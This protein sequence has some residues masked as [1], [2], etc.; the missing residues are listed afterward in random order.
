MAIFQPLQI[1]DFIKRWH[2]TFIYCDILYNSFRLLCPYDKLS[3]QNT[4]KRQTDYHN[5]R[6]LPH[7][8]L[9]ISPASVLLNLYR[10]LISHCPL[11]W[12]WTFNPH[13]R[14]LWLETVSETFTKY[15]HTIGHWV[16]YPV[17]LKMQ[18]S[19]VTLHRMY[20]K[21]VIAW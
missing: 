13:V 20:L 15:L 5:M 2:H 12:D 18:Y 14:M 4:D 6:I 9:E 1:K 8:Q 16:R 7:N 17:L 10:Y 21:K 19:E 3:R 11:T